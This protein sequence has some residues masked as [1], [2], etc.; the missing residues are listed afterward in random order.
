V[1]FVEFPAVPD[2]FGDAVDEQLART[3]KTANRT[4]TQ[5]MLERLI[6]RPGGRT[7]QLARE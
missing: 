6:G 7:W 2:V 1:V 5:P 4:S 3:V